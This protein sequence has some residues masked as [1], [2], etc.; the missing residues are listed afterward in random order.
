MSG[1]YLYIKDKIQNDKAI[2]F[3]IITLPLFALIVIILE[4]YK[5]ITDKYRRLEFGERKNLPS[6]TQ[7]QIDYM[8]ISEKRNIVLA[9]NYVLDF[10]DYKII[11][12]GG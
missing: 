2:P 10:G 8:I 11:H 9:D 7:E 3:V 5:R 6:F 1:A 12:P 4:V